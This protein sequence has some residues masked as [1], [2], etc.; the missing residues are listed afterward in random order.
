MKIAISVESTAD[1]SDQLKQKYNLSVL[2]FHVILGEEDKKDTPE[3]NGQVLFDYVAKTGILPKT[4]AIS[5]F[6]YEEYFKELLKQNEAVIHIC[7]SSELSSSYANAANATKNMPNVFVIDS[8]T[9][10]TGIALLALSAYDKIQKG[11]E[12]QTILSELEKE[13]HRVQASFVINN[14]KY[15]HKGGRCSSIALLGANILKIKPEIKLV[16][17]KMIV[18]KKYRGKH[19]EVLQTYLD[20]VLK[21]NNPDKTRVF[22]TYSSRVAFADKML[23]RLKQEGFQEVLQTSAGATICSHCGPETIGILFIN[24]AQ[25]K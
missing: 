9:L 22:V 18:G 24:K 1:L 14:L 21:E 10:S 4:A 25:E 16:N 20:D 13:K 7:L 8:Q 2:P 23:A 19:E 11:E 17:G 12:I 5:I 15:L 6:E 3:I